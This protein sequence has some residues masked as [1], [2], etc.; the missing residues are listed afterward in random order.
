MDEPYHYEVLPL[1]TPDDA[2]RWVEYLDIFDFG[3]LGRRAGDSY[4]ETY[5]M[6]CREDRATLG[7]VTTVGPGLDGR[8]PVAGFTSS[9]FTMNAGAGIVDCLVI[10]SIAVRPSHR[11]RGL[12]NDMMRRHLSDARDSRL[13]CAVLSASEGAI[14]GRYGFGVATRQMDIEID[15]ARFRFRDDLPLAP[16][17]I[18]FVDPSFLDPHFKRISL[19]QQDRYTGAQGRVHGHRLTFT[20]AWDRT[21]EGPSRSLRA[22]IHFDT[23]GEPDGFAVFKHKGWHSSP[24]TTEVWQVCSPDPAIDR[25]LWQSL[26]SIDLVEKLTY[27]LSHP[28]DPLPL[29]LQDPRAV[30]IK[31]F[32]D[33]VWLRILDM[34]LAT[35]QRRFESDGEVVVR[36]D[37][38]MGF[39]DGTWRFTVTD[40]HGVAEESDAKPQVRLGVDVL[41]M[42]WFGDRSATTL[43]LAGLVSGDSQGIHY[44]SQMFAT[45]APPVNLSQF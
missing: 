41:A 26:V 15:T 35:S 40:G 4:L 19:A 14:Y 31:E 5:R 44:L 23:D 34:P 8:Q 30:T 42:M 39:C 3:F 1:D 20:G 9:P 18:E 12:L 43:S 29:A 28:G 6:Q 37:D 36:I 11:R 22:V 16:G 13:A 27:G 2:P 38:N 17:Q 7:M 32:S 33:G 25:A 24:V 45:S 10:N 21:D